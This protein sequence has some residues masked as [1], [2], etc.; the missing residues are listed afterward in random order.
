MNVKD[1]L[2]LLSNGEN[3]RVEFKSESVS[4]AEHA[5]AMV[6]FLNGGGTILLGAEDD[7]SIT[8]ISAS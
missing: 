8:G 7:A 3:S 1:V 4:N 5:V 2:E 6:S